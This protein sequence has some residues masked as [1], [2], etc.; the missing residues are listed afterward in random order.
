MRRLG[1]PALLILLLFV[2][3][4][5]DLFTGNP[6][7]P[8]YEEYYQGVE[9]VRMTIPPNSLPST[10]YYHEDDP[11]YNTVDI[12]VKLENEGASM[13][14]GAVFLS[15]YDPGM[16]HVEGVNLDEFIM[17][18]CS[19]NL[20]S[21]TSNVFAD[22]NIQCAGVGGVQINRGQW[23]A[24]IQDI[25]THMESIGVDIF[26]TNQILRDIDLRIGGEDGIDRVSLGWSDNVDIDYYGKGVGLLVFV[27]SMPHI[28]FENGKE[29]IMAG[30]NYYFPGGE[31]EYIE[32]NADIRN[33]PHGL[34]ETNQRFLV[35]NCY[36]Y[37]TEASPLVCLDPEPYSEDRKVC[38]PNMITFKGSQG[39]PVAVTSV[40]QENT[41]TKAFFTIR[42]SNVGDGRVY[43][44]WAMDKCN[45]YGGT[46]RTTEKDL[47][48]V[49]LGDVRIGDDQLECVPTNRFIRLENGQ[50][51]IT[52]SYPY[53]FGDIRS[54]Y[55]TP[56]IIS[57]YYA[58]GQTLER[59][60]RIKRAS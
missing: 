22:F 29:Y 32:F 39:A 12:E 21:L 54:A 13:T 48:I 44:P 57:L 56:L 3:A 26:G 2:L 50:G 46:G 23:E 31:T 28:D 20:L 42:F 5:C 52:C 49:Y 47:N 7:D 38:T 10:L 60:L 19:V 16:I 43:A 45:P 9:G 51:Q 1:S 35:T 34:D 8:K 14:Q 25:G 30:D 18:D 41:R 15:G 27:S 33:W 17:Q 24:N 59:Q 55:E 53:R 6:P 40:S 58:Y 37:S 36:F 4:G 11:D